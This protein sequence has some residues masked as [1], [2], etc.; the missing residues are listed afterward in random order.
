MG[1]PPAPT[2][3]PRRQAAVQHQALEDVH[4]L[5]QL[6]AHRRHRGREDL[7]LPRR[8]A[9][10]P[11]GSGVPR[12]RVVPPPAGPDAPRP[13]QG[14][15]PTCSRWSRSGG[16]CAPRTCPTRGCCATCCGPTPTRMC[17][18]GV[19]TIAA[20]PLPSGQRWWPSSCT[21]TTWTSSAGHTR[22]RWLSFWG[23]CSGDTSAPYRQGSPGGFPSQGH[24]WGLGGVAP[25][26]G[27]DP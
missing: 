5:L 7:L 11:R 2:P 27:W 16:S 18:A 8:W 4:R 9:R 22:Y 26:G 21:S 15:L 12:D 19:R 14:C 20:S 13:V 25:G 17:R 3:L 10:H 1:G 6:L 23:V 24:F